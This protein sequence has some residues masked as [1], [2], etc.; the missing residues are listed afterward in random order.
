M[1]HVWAN[2]QHTQ[3]RLEVTAKNIHGDQGVD[4]RK[5]YTATYK[6][7]MWNG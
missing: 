5:Y 6:T 7:F 4:K 1:W 3:F 2:Q